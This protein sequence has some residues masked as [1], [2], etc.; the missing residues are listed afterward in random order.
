M[1]FLPNL[2]AAHT[3]VKK[4]LYLL[5]QSSQRLH[6][7]SHLNTQAKRMTETM[8]IQC[9]LKAF[10]D[11]PAKGFVGGKQE[12][13]RG[14]VRALEVTDRE[15]RKA[16]TEWKVFSRNMT[17]IINPS[18]SGSAPEWLPQEG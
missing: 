17:V 18:V 14:G 2:P 13:W 8:T 11:G 15:D 6:H 12:K 5:T 4:N 10:R 16:G 3:R 1:K 9:V 7:G